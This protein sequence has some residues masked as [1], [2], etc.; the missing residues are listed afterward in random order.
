MT[1]WS[2]M[3]LAWWRGCWCHACLYIPYATFGFWV[4]I[5]HINVTRHDYNRKAPRHSE[6]W[7]GCH[8]TATASY[9]YQPLKGC[10]FFSCTHTWFHSCHPRIFLR[11]CFLRIFQPITLGCYTLSP[12]INLKARFKAAM[13]AD[14]DVFNVTLVNEDRLLCCYAEPPIYVPKGNDIS[15]TFCYYWNP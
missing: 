8:R 9:Q 15:Q 7:W 14:V 4:M 11:M 12:Q 2:I 13:N 3:I 10:L 6:S 5:T 1:S